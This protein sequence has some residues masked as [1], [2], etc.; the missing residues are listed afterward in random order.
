MFNPQGG[1]TRK[2]LNLQ[3]VQAFGLVRGQL[4][5]I[6]PVG[7][8]VGPST[9]DCSDD[10]SQ[11]CLVIVTGTESNNEGTVDVSVDEGDGYAV[12]TSGKSW[13]LNETVFEACYATLLGVRVTNPTSDAWQGLV[14]ILDEEGRYVPLECVDCGTG[15]STTKIIVDGDSYTG[16]NTART[17]CLDASTCTLILSGNNAG[18][19]ASTDSDGDPFLE[20]DF[21]RVVTIDRVRVV[22]IP[23]RLRWKRMRG[24]RPRGKREGQNRARGKRARGKK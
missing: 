8:E 17:K 24:N 4:E 3:L 23:D 10:N 11:T 15:S 7:I 14:E 20:V 13:G 2:A 5:Q 21:G 12:V 22:A 6:E 1:A 9:E 18:C 19:F 16:S